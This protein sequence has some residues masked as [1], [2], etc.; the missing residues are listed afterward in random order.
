MVVRST[1][2]SLS[3]L[4]FLSPALAED[5]SPSLYESVTIVTGQREET[6]TPGI[7]RCFVDVLQKVSGDQRL[8]GEEAVAKLANEASSFVTTYRYHDQLWKRPIH[9]E[10]GT[11]DRPHDLT[12]DFDP[13][14]VDALLRS[15]GREPWTAP[16]P[17]VAAFVAV[18]Q[19]PTTY[20][21]SSDGVNG[22]GQAE[23]LAE[24]GARVGLPVAVPSQEDL[25][26]A[27]ID[28][29]A[30]SSA[31]PAEASAAAA[32]LGATVPLVG[33][34]RFSDADL[35]WIADWRVSWHG[36][37]YRWGIIGV[38]FD[39]AFLNGL[40]GVAQIASGHGAPS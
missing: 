32:A 3:F 25:V 38:N 5:G 20:V 19:G 9:D 14:K 4:A 12:V 8:A 27:H 33:T 2:L 18:Q 11:R 1:A 28:Y 35:G 40:R 13:A 29:A 37:T 23:A 22:Y 30:I 15:L 16:R 26:A 21:T 36:L 39:A 34:M 24:V 31:D 17:R 7:Q 10:Q 6:R